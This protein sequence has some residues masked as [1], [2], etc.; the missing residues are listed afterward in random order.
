MHQTV[1]NVHPY[2]ANPQVPILMPFLLC[3]CFVKT[4][5]VRSQVQLSS[6]FGTAERLQA[7]FLRTVPVGLIASSVFQYVWF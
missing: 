4:L 1:D 3:I 2:K 7:T 5:K 6:T